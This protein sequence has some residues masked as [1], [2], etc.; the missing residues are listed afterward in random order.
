M[1]GAHQ[2][3]PGAE[4]GAL[5][6]EGGLG[7]LRQG[8]HGVLRVHV[9]QQHAQAV[10]ALQ[11]LDAPVDVLRLQQVVP[12]CADSQASAPLLTNVKKAQLTS[13]MLWT[14]ERPAKDPAVLNSV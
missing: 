9:A 5:V 1:R 3:A 2:G 4:E 10:R 8:V 14:R 12:V 6:E 7:D 11:L 13:Q